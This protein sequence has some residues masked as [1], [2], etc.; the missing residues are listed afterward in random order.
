MSLSQL[1]LNGNSIGD[2]G[3]G[4]LASSLLRGALPSL[5]AGLY[6]HDNEVGDAGLAAL[7]EAAAGGALDSLQALWLTNNHGKRE[8]AAVRAVAL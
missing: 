7:A 2:R 4:A 8:T 3:A 1:N 6:L 5:R